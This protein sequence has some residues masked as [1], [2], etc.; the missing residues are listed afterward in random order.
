LHARQKLKGTIAVSIN[1]ITS[2]LRR[3]NP[4]ECAINLSFLRN[5]LPRMQAILRLAGD[6]TI[7]IKS[8][9][10]N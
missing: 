7:M 3:R 4:I 5:V 2:V 8:F 6:R 10:V 1:S 9:F